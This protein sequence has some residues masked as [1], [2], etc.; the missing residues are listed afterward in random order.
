VFPTAPY[1]LCKGV[2]PVFIKNKRGKITNIAAIEAK[3]RSRSRRA[4]SVSKYSLL[5]LT[6]T[7][8]LEVASQGINVNAIC[9]GPVRSVMDDKRLEYDARRLGVSIAETRIS[10]DSHWAQIGT[11]GNRSGG[12]IASGL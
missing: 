10:H 12:V 2:L 7:L 3:N 11:E 5:G 8:A 1:R 9:P 6:R 4:Y